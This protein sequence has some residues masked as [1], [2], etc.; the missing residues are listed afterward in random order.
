[1]DR[2]DGVEGVKTGR[3]RRP[4]GIFAIS[5]SRALP[6]HTEAPLRLA[7][8]EFRRYISPAFPD[9]ACGGA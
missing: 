8:S 7:L 9:K 6:V 3:Q 4:G 2:D 1:M 5:V